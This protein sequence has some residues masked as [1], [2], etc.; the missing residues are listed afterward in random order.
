MSNKLKLIQKIENNSKVYTGDIFIVPNKASIPVNLKKDYKDVNNR[1]NEY[2][3]EKLDENIKFYGK[4]TIDICLANN[5]PCYKA[6]A[7]KDVINS[8]GKSFLGEHQIECWVTGGENGENWGDHGLHKEELRTL[9]FGSKIKSLFPS[10]FPESFFKDKK[11][12]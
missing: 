11:E 4:D 10:Y 2:D 6:F 8:Y 3:Q 7:I 12:D 5:L 9:Q 1:F